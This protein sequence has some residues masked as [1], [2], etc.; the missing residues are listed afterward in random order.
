MVGCLWFGCFFIALLVKN[1]I[2]AG[3]FV[4]Q[5]FANKISTF[6]ATDLIIASLVFWVFLL[7]EAKKY[8]LRHWWVYFIA[9]LTAGL[10]FALPLFLYFRESQLEKLATQ[11][12]RAT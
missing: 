12:D 6:F 8:A 5:L 11:S 7:K 9:S 4:Q 2:D 3:L 10:S 1:G